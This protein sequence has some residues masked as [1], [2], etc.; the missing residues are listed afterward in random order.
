MLCNNSCSVFLPGMFLFFGMLTNPL[1]YRSHIVQNFE[2][3]LREHPE[4]KKKKNL[5]T[6]PDFSDFIKNIEKEYY[7]LGS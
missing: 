1:P 6:A 2:R 5:K 3:T 4:K 7:C